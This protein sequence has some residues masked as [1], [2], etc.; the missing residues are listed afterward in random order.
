MAKSCLKYSSPAL[1]ADDGTEKLIK[2]RILTMKEVK[3][4]DTIDATILP[5]TPARRI[6]I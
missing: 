4:P 5:F 2:V 1:I 6:L 3:F